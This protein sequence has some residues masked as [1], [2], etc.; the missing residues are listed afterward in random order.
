MGRGG[1]VFFFSL[2]GHYS[3]VGFTNLSLLIAC[4]RL[5]FL[6]CVCQISDI[7]RTNDD[8]LE[9]LLVNLFFGEA[10]MSA[11]RCTTFMVLN[12]LNFSVWC[13]VAVDS[14]QTSAMQCLLHL[15]HL[16]FHLN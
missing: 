14:L 11:S 13:A 9:N 8:F 10:V 1:L 15:L 3:I 2:L 6:V 4:L 5:D 12:S 16:I 7:H